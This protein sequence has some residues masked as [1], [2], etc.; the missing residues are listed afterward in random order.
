ME[1]IME[2]VNEIL[3]KL[4]TA[5]NTNKNE[6]ENKLVSLGD[7]ALPF[8]VQEL[9]SIR[10][11]KRGIIAMTLIRL[12]HQSVKYLEDAARKNKDF[13]WIADYLIHEIDGSRAV[14]VA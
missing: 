11:L 13:Q 10:G 4:D 2:T 14:A 1:I 12:G 9:Q 6:L 5:D 8:L 7:K 3:S